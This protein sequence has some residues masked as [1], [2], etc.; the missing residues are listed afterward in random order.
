MVSFT[1]TMRRHLIRLASSP[2]TSSR[3]AKFGWVPFAVCN[4]WQRSR[5]DNLP[6]AVENSGP[7]FTRLF[8]KVHEI[9]RRCMRPSQ[10]PM[11]LP[12][13]LCHVSFN[14]YSLLSLEVVEKLNKCKRFLAPDVIVSMH[15]TFL[16]DEEQSY[17]S[18]AGLLVTETHASWAGTCQLSWRHHVLCKLL[19]RDQETSWH[20]VDFLA[21][22]QHYCRQ[23]YF[24]F[25]FC[26]VLH[27]NIS[28]CRSNFSDISTAK[29]LLFPVAEN[30]R[31]P[32]WNS[33]RLRFR[34]SP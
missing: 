23:L 1:F 21:S 18:L 15:W 4:A 8:T 7:I 14:S 2:F 16:V 32:Y 33:A 22:R 30:K 3:L 26:D 24:R 28:I 29:M 20:D 34:F 10:F 17:S 13:C 12:D 5:T 19:I 9:F 6:R 31:P 27:R 11:P 25:R